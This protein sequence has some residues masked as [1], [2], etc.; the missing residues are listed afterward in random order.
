[1]HHHDCLQQLNR[2]PEADNPR[3]HE[4]HAAAAATVSTYSP[5]VG[6]AHESPL[7]GSPLSEPSR[8]RVREGE[9]AY[10][11]TKRNELRP[12]ISVSC[13]LSK[14]LHTA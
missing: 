1:V 4:Q 5:K 9:P 8:V 14:A 11:I 2:T 12:A 13:S 10:A 7:G 3:A 6:R